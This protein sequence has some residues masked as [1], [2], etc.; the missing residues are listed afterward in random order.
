MNSIKL[1]SLRI[2]FAQL[3]TTLD[4]VYLPTRD[5]EWTC[6]AP[7]SNKWIMLNYT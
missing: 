4:E 3:Q 2:D 6:I 1:H 5:F 7:R